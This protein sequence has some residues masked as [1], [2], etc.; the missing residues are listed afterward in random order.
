MKFGYC[1]EALHGMQALEMYADL[2]SYGDKYDI[3]FLD[4]LMPGINGIQ[5]LKQ[6]RLLEESYNLDVGNQA[7]IVI[8]TA[9]SDEQTMHN[10]RAEKCDDYLIK[11][12][13]MRQIL[14]Q[15]FKLV[16]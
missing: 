6:I 5:T 14:Q 7:K 9:F 12:F 15:V 3:I 8:T 11:P 4:V 2:L 10:A 13:D 1:E 16:G